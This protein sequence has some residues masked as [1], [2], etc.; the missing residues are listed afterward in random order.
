MIN[1]DE[2]NSALPNYLLKKNIYIVSL[3][4]LFKSFISRTLGYPVLDGTVCTQLHFQVNFRTSHQ[5]FHTH[6]HTHS[7]TV[8]VLFTGRIVPVWHNT[9]RI[10]FI[11][12]AYTT[13]NVTARVRAFPYNTLF[14]ASPSTTVLK[15]WRLAPVHATLLCFKLQALFVAEVTRVVVVVVVV[16]VPVGLSSHQQ[17]LLLAHATVKGL[18]QGWVFLA[19]V[20]GPREADVGHGRGR[21]NFRR[22]AGRVLHLLGLGPHHADPVRRLGMRGLAPRRAT[23]RLVRA[24]PNAGAVVVQYAFCCLLF[25]AWLGH[26]RDEGG[27]RVLGERL[28]HKVLVRHF[29]LEIAFK[30]ARF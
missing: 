2:V 3:N 1:K 11:H 27:G 12:H 25:Q 28:V 29:T 19:A 6:K 16:D 10:R 7:C 30:K 18:G 8:Y 5:S 20:V 13:V 21:G 23:G 9:C 22:H 17:P 14:R 26:E 4:F 24:G 15:A